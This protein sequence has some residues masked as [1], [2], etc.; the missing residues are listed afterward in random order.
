MEYK[1]SNTE[2]MYGEVI[3]YHPSS[4]TKT[5]PQF[6]FVSIIMPPPSKT[7]KNASTVHNTYDF[8]T[9]GIPPITKHFLGD[10]HA[11]QSRYVIKIK[12]EILIGDVSGNNTLFRAHFRGYSGN[13]GNN[14]NYLHHNRYYE[15]RVVVTILP[16]P[17]RIPRPISSN[18]P[19]LVF[20]P[21]PIINTGIFK[22]MC[23]MARAICLELMDGEVDATQIVDYAQ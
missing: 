3:S 7:C 15:A 12:R 17:L 6:A 22:E 5:A 10:M 23:L 9:H 11:H 16:A 2:Y 14:M 4:I 21:I 13:S 18:D 19:L 20:L 1:A 8:R